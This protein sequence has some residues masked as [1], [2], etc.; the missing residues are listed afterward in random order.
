LTPEREL[1]QANSDLSEVVS[2]P[3]VAGG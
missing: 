1:E 3:N 2:K